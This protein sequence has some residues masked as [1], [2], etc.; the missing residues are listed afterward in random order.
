MVYSPNGAWIVNE[1]VG[2][3][4]VKDANKNYNKSKTKKAELC[5]TLT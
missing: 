2:E 5:K 3:K 4:N 1:W